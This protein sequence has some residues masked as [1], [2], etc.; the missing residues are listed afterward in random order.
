MTKRKNDHRK[1]ISNQEV[2]EANSFDKIFKENFEP[3]FLPFVERELNLV[4]KTAKPLKEKMQTTLEREV[5]FLYEIETEKGEKFILHI[6]VESQNNQ[7]MIYRIAEY[8]GMIFRR[9]KLPV[10]H[11]VICL[12]EKKS[13]IRTHLKEE[14][15]FSSFE[16]I[17]LHNL[18]TNRLLSSQIPEVVMLAILSN[19]PKEDIEIILQKISKRFL[20][21]VKNKA[22]LARY[23]SQLTILA[24]L[25]NAQELTNKFFRKMALTIDYRQNPFFMDA[26]EKGLKVGM[27]K[28]MEKGSAQKEQEK[29]HLFV[30]NLILKTNNDDAT[31]ADLAGV[32]VKFVKKVRA[33]LKLKS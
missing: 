16:K 28:G 9:T 27:E 7:E 1:N 25:R 5:D 12:S 3:L 19:Y 24:Q 30:R 29:N 2:D 32:P 22:K 4:I 8:H 11:V 31:I 6:E 21:L 26:I 17:E 10:K 18:D 15:I 23:I 33:E 20:T 14:E 13:L